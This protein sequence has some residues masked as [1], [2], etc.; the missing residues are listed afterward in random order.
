MRTVWS[1][2][3]MRM[4]ESLCDPCEAICLIDPSPNPASVNLPDVAVVEDSKAFRAPLKD[5]A[6]F[7]GKSIGYGRFTGEC[8]AG[9]QCALRMNGVMI[10]LTKTWRQRRKVRGNHVA[11]GTAIASFRDGRYGN[12]HAAIFVSQDDDGIVVYD[13]FNRPKK[14]WGKRKLHFDTNRSR[15]PSNNGDYFYTI[16]T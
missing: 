12:D 9:V 6:K 11:P 13:Q 16:V 5:I 14:P 10:G 8:A 3:V 4:D 15:G 7:D 1:V 2:E